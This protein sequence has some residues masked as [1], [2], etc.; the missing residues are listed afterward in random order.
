M[1]NTAITRQI[2]TFRHFK[3]VTELVGGEMLHQ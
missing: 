2:Q 1:S 3:D